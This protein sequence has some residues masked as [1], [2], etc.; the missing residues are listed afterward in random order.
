MSREHKG[1]IP[2]SLS[3]FDTLTSLL[4]RLLSTLISPGH[5]SRRGNSGNRGG[6]GGD[7]CA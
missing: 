3:E 4:S 1:F 7:I 6:S 5:H 2:L